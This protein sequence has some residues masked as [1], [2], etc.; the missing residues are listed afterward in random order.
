VWEN[1]GDQKWS[2][3]KP[4]VA[5]QKPGK[6]N[7]FHIREDIRNSRMYEVEAKVLSTKPLVSPLPS[8]W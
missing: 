8:S 5:E 1:L 2:N 6:I 4:P 7:P 3:V